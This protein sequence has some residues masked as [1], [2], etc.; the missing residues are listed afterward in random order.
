MHFKA[1]DSETWTA[2]VWWR[3]HLVLRSARASWCAGSFP[4]TLRRWNGGFSFTM[5]IVTVRPQVRSMT[6]IH[7]ITFHVIVRSVTVKHCQKAV[8][9]QVAERV[10]RVCGEN[11]SAVVSFQG[12]TSWTTG[13]VSADILCFSISEDLPHSHLSSSRKVTL[14]V[15]ICCSKYET[16]SSSCSLEKPTSGS[17]CLWSEKNPELCKLRSTTNQYKKPLNYQ[18]RGQQRAQAI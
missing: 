9:L 14:F 5:H 6:A 17:L 3:H 2:M 15:Q 18:Q 13:K 16:L 11:I 4:S 7:S 8:G 10:V 1:E 12:R